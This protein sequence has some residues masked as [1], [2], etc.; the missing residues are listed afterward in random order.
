ME[1][2]NLIPFFGINRQYATLRDELL[3]ASDI[4]Y[5]TGQVLDGPYVRKFEEAIAQRCNRKYAVAVNSCTQG[6]IFALRP[7]SIKKLLIPNISFPATLNSVL[8]AQSTEE[9]QFEICDTDINGLI[10]LQSLDYALNG[11][12]I[13]TIMYPN[14]WGHTVD[15]DNFQVVANFFNQ[16]MFVIEDAAQSFGAYYKDQPSGSLGDVS[17][18]SFDPTKNLPNYGS[19]GMILTDEAEFAEVFMNYRDNGKLRDHDIAG[20][21]SKMSESD[22]AQMLVKLQYFDQWQKRRTEIA[23]YYINELYQYVDIVLPGPDVTSAWHKFI[24]RTSLRHNL[25]SYMARHGVETRIHYSQGMVDL[26]VLGSTNYVW[27]ADQFRES[28]AFT[29]ECLSLPIYPELTD[30]EVEHVVETIHGY[31]D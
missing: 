24:I 31:L 7:I 23:E 18:L 11:A 26:P 21:N 30:A 15:W 3:D 17:V 25:Q 10:D 20:T 27:A 2:K 1:E 4:V 14:L 13:D 6:L 12:G 5:R 22:C 8:L 9:I 29:K 28:D 19:G 16:D